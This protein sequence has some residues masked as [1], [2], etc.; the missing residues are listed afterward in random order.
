MNMKWTIGSLIFL[1]SICT[2]AKP[3][4]VPVESQIELNVIPAV[5]LPNDLDHRAGNT[6]VEEGVSG[7]RVRFELSI[8]WTGKGNLFPLYAALKINNQELKSSYNE[9]FMP[10]SSQDTLAYIFGTSENF[11]RPD[12][13]YTTGICYLDFGKLPSPKKDLTGSERLSVKVELSLVGS[14]STEGQMEPVVFD[15]TVFTEVLYV[16]GSVSK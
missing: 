5:V 3:L 9:L 11:L 7:P 15:K 2:F 6:C 16:N 4:A 13:P 1:L 10:H 8:K 14:V 12:K